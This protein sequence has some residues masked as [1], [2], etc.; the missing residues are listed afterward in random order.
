M[1]QYKVIYYQIYPERQAYI[2]RDGHAHYYR[3]ISK[4][5]DNRI[6][7]LTYNKREVRTIYNSNYGN[8]FIVI[9]SEA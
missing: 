4:A 8:A 6:S 2:Y 7:L 9:T 1:K 3:S 5:S